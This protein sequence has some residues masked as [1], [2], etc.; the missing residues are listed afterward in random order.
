MIQI[1]IIGLGVMGAIFAKSL[2][3]FPES[4]LAAVS[5]VNESLAKQFA[6][7]Y[8]AAAY[9]DYNEM[10]EKENLDAVLICTPDQY[11]LDPARSACAANV[12]I[13]LEKPLSTDSQSGAEILKLAQGY[14]KTFM[15]GH[16]LRWDPRFVNGYNSIK[17]GEIGN[18]LH[19]R[20]WRETS[21]DNGIRLGG[22]CSSMFFVGVHDL[23]IMLWY[24]GCGVERVYAESRYGKLRDMGVNTSDAVF[25]TLRFQNGAIAT[26][27]TS[28]VLPKTQGQQRSNI[29]D[30]G[31]EI[32]GDKGM[33]SIEAYNIGM[34]VQTEDYIHYPDIIFSPD[35][36]GSSFGIYT[37]EMFHFLNCIRTGA[38]PATSIQDAYN[39]VR[40]AEA[41]EQ[42]A[43]SGR[44][45]SLI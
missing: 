20:A 28:W 25:A 18:I 17:K 16:T 7:R 41:I 27:N 29:M 34:C 44:P 35:M 21:I 22:R 3:R 33:I 19:M 26:L 42:S 31:M 8:Q 32:V 13:F 38:A 11:H 12:H 6:A 1:G 39:A 4:R 40:I 45:V 37:E 36:H 14:N 43:A 15:I 5:D 10:L 24:A 2:E 9:S 30:K 23:D